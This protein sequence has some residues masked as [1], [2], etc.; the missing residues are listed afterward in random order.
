MQYAMKGMKVLVEGT[1]R[2]NAYVDKK[3]DVKGNIAINATIVEFLSKRNDIIEQNDDEQNTEGL[4]KEQ[5][6]Q[7]NN[8][9]IPF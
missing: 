6:I 7:N 3:G 8:D 1:P 9:D 4:I 2:C 5:D